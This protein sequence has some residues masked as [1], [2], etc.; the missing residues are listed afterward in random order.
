M[1]TPYDTLTIFALEFWPT[2][3]LVASLE[4]PIPQEVLACCKVCNN[5]LYNDKNVSIL[6]VRVDILVKF[7]SSLVTTINPEAPKARHIGMYSV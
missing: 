2:K 7:L 1:T 4:R 5:E 3:S 6:E